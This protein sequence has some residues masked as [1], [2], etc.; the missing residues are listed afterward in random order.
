MGRVAEII[1]AFPDWK[2]EVPP[3][4]SFDR[5]LLRLT[6]YSPDGRLLAIEVLGKVRGLDAADL[7]AVS[8]IE[9]D[10]LTYHV[11]DPIAMLRAKAANVREINQDG[12]PPRNDRPHLHLI[13]QC[14]PLFL[15]DM[16]RQASS[17]PSEYETFS[18]IVS[19]AFR[20]LSDSRTQKTLLKEGIRPLELIPPELTNSPIEKVRTTCAHQLPRLKD[21]IAAY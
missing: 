16:H 11:L 6:T 21:A 10:G 5:R 18:T 14:V 9:R 7:K 17:N 19:R 4:W 12:P 13:A 3:L 8:K 15:S 1:A 2:S 20:A